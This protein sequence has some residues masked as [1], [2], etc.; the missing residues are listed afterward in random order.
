MSDNNFFSME[1]LVEFGMGMSIA[2]QMANSMNQTLNHM[3]IPGAGK[4]MTNNVESIYYV[5]LEGKSAGPFS[6]TELS[7]MIAEKKVFK[8]TYVWKPGMPQWNLVE[9]VEEILRFVALMPPP[10]PQN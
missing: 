6:L 7:R 2:N 5:V 9:N 8:E 1:K 3:D 4:A 10:I